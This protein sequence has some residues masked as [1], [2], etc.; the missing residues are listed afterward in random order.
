[1]NAEN[2]KSTDIIENIVYFLIYIAD[3]YRANPWHYQ[4]HIEVSEVNLG[5]LLRLP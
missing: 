5:T 3:M 2:I 1:M 4:S